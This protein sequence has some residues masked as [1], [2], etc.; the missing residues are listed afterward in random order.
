[1]NPVIADRLARLHIQVLAEAGR[2]VLLARDTCV[3]LVERTDAGLGSIGGTG[4]MTEAG[5]AYLVWREGRAILVGRGGE[6]AAGEAQVEVIRRF[7][8]DL[9]A[10]LAA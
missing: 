1:V 4:V 8:A 5:L 6:S 7:S 9:K 10:A 3:A 2:H